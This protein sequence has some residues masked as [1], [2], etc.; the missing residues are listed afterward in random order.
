MG[1]SRKIKK[2]AKGVLRHEEA[3]VWIARKKRNS[4]HRF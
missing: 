4:P 3:I 2:K 1:N